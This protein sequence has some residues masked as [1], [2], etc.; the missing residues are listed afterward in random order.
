MTKTKMGQRESRMMKALSHPL[1]HR[2]LEELNEEASSPS[3]LAV[4]LDEPLGN[5]SYHVK[6]LAKLD[7]I[8][9]VG[10]KPVRGAV[11]H[12][13]KATMRPFFEEEQWSE[14]PVS[15]RNQLLDSTVKK[16]WEH[17]VEGA[18]AGGLD[19]P[20]THVSLTALELDSA[21]HDEMTALL[22]QTLE[23]ALQIQAESAERAGDGEAERTELT[24]FHY[25]R[26]DQEDS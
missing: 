6:A 13:Y 9:L 18:N 12:F 4:K 21:G 24:I 11:E 25:H 19:D 1:R 23:R 20:N 17:L 14:L 16:A 3:D 26:P 10:T 22:A 5:V 8:E 15:I 7:A 2:I